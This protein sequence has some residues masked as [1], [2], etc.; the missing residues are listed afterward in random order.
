MREGII[1]PLALCIIRHNGRLLVMDGHDKKKNQKFYRLL[2]GGIELGE[3][4]EDA[5]KREFK[6]ELGAELK[7]IKYVATIEN[8]FTFEGA[9]GHE[10]VLLYE[11]ELADDS[12]N[13]MELMPILDSE[14]KNNALWKDISE[15]KEN[16]SILYPDNVIQYI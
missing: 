7:D 3:Y 11:A 16:K 12:L 14:S 9:Q 2:G 1:R 4:G 10:I 15:F 5:L 13:D 8:I 6:E